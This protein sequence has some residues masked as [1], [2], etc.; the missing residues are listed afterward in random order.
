M[1]KIRLT[2]GGAKKRGGASNWR[3]CEQRAPRRSTAGTTPAR[4]RPC[5]WRGVSRWC[6][7]AWEAF[8]SADDLPY[9]SANIDTT[10]WY[11]AEAPQQ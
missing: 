8:L 10:A 1:V 2:R 3:Q 4:V 7:V 6:P 11:G 9:L 5:S